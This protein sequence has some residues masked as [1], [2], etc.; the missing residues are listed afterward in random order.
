MSCS[1]VTVVSEQNKKLY[2]NYPTSGGMVKM[3]QTKFVNMEYDFGENYFPKKVPA[4]GVL[5]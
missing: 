4:V 5:V 3:N 1:L 2:V